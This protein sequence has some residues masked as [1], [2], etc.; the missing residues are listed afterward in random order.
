MEQDD[1][2]EDVTVAT[3]RILARTT[4]SDNATP[5]QHD[6]L[7][8]RRHEDGKCA[9]YHMKKYGLCLTK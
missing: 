2:D 6:V 1:E 7:R 5:E 3:A 9:T 8:K 4:L